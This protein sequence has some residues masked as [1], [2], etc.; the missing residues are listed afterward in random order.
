VVQCA[1]TGVK[2]GVATSRGMSRQA[3]T[4]HKP[5]K[6]HPGR[7]LTGKAGR[8]SLAVPGAIAMAAAG[9]RRSMRAQAG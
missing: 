4:P 9:N 6:S 7:L 3:T 8:M 1:G 5:V 2:A